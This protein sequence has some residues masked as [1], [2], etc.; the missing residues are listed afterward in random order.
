MRQYCNDTFR[1]I[2]QRLD[3]ITGLGHLLLLSLLL[4]VVVVVVMLVAVVAMLV[5]V[6]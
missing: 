1:G 6:A 2:T 4:V 3:D 5:V